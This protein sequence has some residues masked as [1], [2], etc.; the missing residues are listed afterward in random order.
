MERGTLGFIFNLQSLTENNSEVGD[1]LPSFTHFDG[2]TL[3][4]K[5]ENSTYIT[6]EDTILIT[7]HFLNSKNP[8]AIATIISRV[9]SPT[10]TAIDVATTFKILNDR[11]KL[12]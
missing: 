12:F 6:T 1:A 5:G 10:K 9:M 8:H 11:S 2:D 3:F 7:T 4:L